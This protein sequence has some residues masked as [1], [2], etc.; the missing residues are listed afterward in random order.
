V[1]RAPSP[2]RPSWLEGLAANLGSRLETCSITGLQNTAYALPVLAAA[3]GNPP[4]VL[5]VAAQAQAMVDAAMAAAAE[6][7]QQYVAA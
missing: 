7:Q 5:A 6:E 2:R 1:W 3:A 4:A